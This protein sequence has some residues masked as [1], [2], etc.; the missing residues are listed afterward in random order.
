HGP[1]ALDH[2]PLT[3]PHPRPVKIEKI[4]LL[5]EKFLG[6]GARIAYHDWVRPTTAGRPGA[7]RAEEETLASTAPRAGEPGLGGRSLVV[8][9]RRTPVECPGQGCPK[10]P[11]RNAPHRGGGPAG[12]RPPFGGPR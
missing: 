6:N 9:A 7:A 11:R 3:I 5:G 4:R 8:P 1:S 10:R 2:D 12:G